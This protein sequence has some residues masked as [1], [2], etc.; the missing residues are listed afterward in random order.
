M[1][2]R[3]LLQLIHRLLERRKSAGGAVQFEHVRAHTMATDIH[4]V[5]NR[6][7]D[8]KANSTRARPQ[9]A[10]P[11]TLRELPLDECEHRLTVWTELGNGAQ[12]IDDAR[13]SAIAQLKARHLQ[14]WRD[15]PASDVTR[16]RLCIC[17]SARQ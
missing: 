9:S 17:G 1:A 2:A 3:P 5:G 7:A 4:S 13:R 16:R 15:K 14:R 8:Y 6:L 12:L 10:S 11:A